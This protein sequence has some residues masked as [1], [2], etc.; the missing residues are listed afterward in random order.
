MLLLVTSQLQPTIRPAPP[1]P[2]DRSESRFKALSAFYQSPG[3]LQLRRQLLGEEA[4]TGGH[5][6]PSRGQGI[7]TL[8][9]VFRHI[10]TRPFPM[11]PAYIHHLAQAISRGP[12]RQQPDRHKVADLAQ[13][14]VIHPTI[15]ANFEESHVLKRDPFPDTEIPHEVGKR[16]P[17][18]SPVLRD[19]GQSQHA[20]WPGP[21]H[22]TR[23]GP[24]QTFAVV[25]TVPALAPEGSNLPGVLIEPVPG[26]I[27]T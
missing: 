8:G 5:F 26:N 18:S 11:T 4:A 16:L 10:P 23:P 1:G 13:M 25:R 22:P 14:V 27:F 15:G 12:G 7:E 20:L 9:D 3:R 17:C 19:V 24:G 6:S 2:P 21:G